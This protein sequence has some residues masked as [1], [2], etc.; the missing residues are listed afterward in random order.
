LID[1]VLNP[2]RDRVA[3]AKFTGDIGLLQDLTTNFASVKSTLK[4]IRFEPPPGFVGGG[5]IVARPPSG[6]LDQMKAGS[7][8]IFDS[9]N[10]AVEA[11]AKIPLN[12]R[13]KA[14]LLISD[15]VNTYGDKKIKDVVEA[16]VRSGVPIFAIGIG[17]EFYDGVD[18]KTLKK[19]TE[20]T[21]GLS[22]KPNKTLSD[23]GVVMSPLESCLRNLYVVNIPAGSIPATT[24]TDVSVEL[25]NPE[26]RKRLR[27]IAPKG[28]SK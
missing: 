23:L 26:L 2:E 4:E 27:V 15:G 5:V 10:K 7:T 12:N 21:G 14:I 19:L 24:L 11:L 17:D 3:L 6:T 8:S 13:R 20:P 9:V 25:V 1:R 18:E 16:S 28:I 22:V